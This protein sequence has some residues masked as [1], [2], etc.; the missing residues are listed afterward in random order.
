MYFPKTVHY[1]RNKMIAHKKSMS[2]KI[3]SPNTL[4]WQLAWRWSFPIQSA[5]KCCA[6]YFYELKVFFLH[7]CY[8]IVK[9][10]MR[11][12]E[13]WWNIQTSDVGSLPKIR[14][15]VECLFYI[16]RFRASISFNF[17]K[18]LFILE[19]E[20]FGEQRGKFFWKVIQNRLI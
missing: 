10:Y 6:Q 4:I 16:Y 13:I 15:G 7:R 11:N 12:L 20:F 5:I 17:L 8:S 2:S 9:N 19:T 1:L 3:T 14:I 18:L